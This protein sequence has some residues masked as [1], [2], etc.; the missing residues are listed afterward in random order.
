MTEY[1]VPKEK[2]EIEFT[3]K[4]S[5][6]IGRVFP[7]S[8]EEEARARIDEMK[9][10]HHDA[11]HNC[12]CYAVRRGGAVRCSDDGEPQGTAG[13]PMLSVF[14][15]EGVSDVCCVV[16][17]YFG[18]VLLGT[19]GLTRA[20]A[21]AAKEA[22]DQAGTLSVQR[23]NRISMTGPY[24][25]LE[26]LKTE[27]KTA[28]GLLD[29]AEYGADVKLHAVIPESNTQE[30]IARVNKLAGGGIEISVTGEFLRAVT[31]EQ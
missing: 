29:E 30:F 28:E 5:R 11:R 19:G 4:R 14:R 10:R 6:F 17:R 31:A 13:Q 20:Y 16:T 18:G 3:E 15:R 23:C 7:V 27:I 25:F 12:W 21:R 9:A 24:S 8:S 2:S 22:L 26:R 1:L